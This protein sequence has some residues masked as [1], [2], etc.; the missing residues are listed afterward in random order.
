MLLVLGESFDQRTVDG[1]IENIGDQDVD[2][3]GYLRVGSA[4]IKNAPFVCPFRDRLE[5]E[6]LVVF[7]DE[8]SS[9]QRKHHKD[10]SGHQDEDAHTI[11]DKIP[12]TRLQKRNV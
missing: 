3:I 1:L 9:I 11:R 12:P 5:V 10:Q 7:V 8:P 2:D 4:S 6:Q